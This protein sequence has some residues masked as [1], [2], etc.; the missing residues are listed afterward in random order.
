MHLT[1]VLAPLPTP[2]DETG[3]LDLRR[4]RAAMPTWLKS[5]LSGFVVLGT[6]AAAGLMDDAEA[7]RVI[8]PGVPRLPLAPAPDAAVV[9]IRAA[10]NTFEDAFV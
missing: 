5:P 9:A 10:L 6:N 4:L 8:D 1:G 2:F 7:E 3:K